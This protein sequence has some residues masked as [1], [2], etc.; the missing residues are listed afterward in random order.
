[1]QKKTSNLKKI[2]PVA[3]AVVAAGAAIALNRS[4]Y[5][6]EPLPTVSG[7]DLTR[8]QGTWYEIA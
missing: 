5:A 1:M 8:Y 3:G 7:V 6:G 4:A 2:I